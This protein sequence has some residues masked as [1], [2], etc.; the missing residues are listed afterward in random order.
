MYENLARSSGESLTEIAGKAIPEI[1]ALI[2]IG[3]SPDGL[4]DSV[5]GSLDAQNYQ[6]GKLV[7]YIRSDIVGNLRQESPGVP[8][9][10]WEAVGIWSVGGIVAALNTALQPRQTG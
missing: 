5:C 2:K 6:L 3:E 4:L 8:H 9:E 10:I 7:R 1:T